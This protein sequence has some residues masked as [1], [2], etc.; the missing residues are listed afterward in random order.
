MVNSFCPY[1]STCGGC[2]NTSLSYADFS[3]SKE[4]ELKA[5]FKE[6]I[7][8]DL[9]KPFVKSNQ[10]EP[11]FFRNKTRFGFLE[12][13]GRVYPSRHSLNSSEANIPIEWCGLQ[14]E[15]CN[16]IIN[17][18]AEYAMSNNWS[19]YLDKSGGQGWLKSI[20]IRESK[21]T[22]QFMVIILTNNEP[23]L[24]R[25]Q[26][27]TTITAKYPNIKSIYHTTTVG[28]NSE[29]FT[30]RL[31]W[32]K[33]YIQDKIGEYTYHI[34]PHSF[35]QTND[36]MLVPLYDEISCL[37]PEGSEVIWDLYAG[38]ASI[39][40]YLSKK[41][42]KILCIESNEQNIKDGM[43][44]I[45]Y[46]K[47]QNIQMVGG[48]VEKA[49]TSKFINDN[50]PSVVIVDPPRAGLSEK[51]LQLLMSIKPNRIIYTSC[52]PATC[53]KNCE[54]LT[55]K[56]YKISSAVGVDCFPRSQHCEMVTCLDKVIK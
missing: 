42:S 19:L 53:L 37:I 2:K 5:M 3:A 20:T 55:Q 17:F 35:F 30:D 34:S 18:V 44:N 32:G 22:N 29:N 7:T 6:I 45:E 26:F 47:L 50:F 13:D 51:T 10:L 15:E 11:K 33:P 48:L 56:I 40:I 36:E 31:I 54:I 25:N 9:W 14:S 8:D 21:S 41:A 52:N 27:C 28:K 39:G 16:S 49:C 38:S 12:V 4:V 1:L 46:N 23:F 43:L 24:D